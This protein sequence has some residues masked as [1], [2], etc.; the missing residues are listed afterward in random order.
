MKF[1]LLLF[2][3]LMVQAVTFGK[4]TS[5]AVLTFT[6]AGLSHG[7]SHWIFQ[8]KFKG[9]YSI[10]GIY[11]PDQALAKNFQDQYN[12]NS[13]LFYSDLGQMLD[14]LK[15][16]GVLAFGPVYDHLKV[17]EEAAPRGIHV[18]VEKPLAANWDHALKMGKLAQDHGIY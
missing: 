6:V 17:V 1:L 3:S 13:N 10:V 4:D 8:D 15:P 11:E 16:D 5:D 7:H 2:L 12:L 14:Q 9:D 18:M